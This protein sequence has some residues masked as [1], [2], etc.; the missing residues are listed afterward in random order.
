MDI[1]EACKILGVKEGD[2]YTEVHKAYK[3]LA[4]IW[5]TDLNRNNY[6]EAN[7]KM[8]EINVAHDILKKY[9]VVPKTV[10]KG[11]SMDSAPVT[12][13]G[14]SRPNTGGYRP[15]SRKCLCCNGTGQVKKFRYASIGKISVKVTCPE[16]DGKGKI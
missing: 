11:K 9:E 1:L 12:P 14:N 3:K 2:P 4:K 6:Q 13:T 10:T 16:C 7:A 5:H 8:V 15:F